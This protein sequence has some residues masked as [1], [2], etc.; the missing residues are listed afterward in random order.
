MD[1]KTVQEIERALGAPQG[2]EELY[3]WLDQ[4]LRATH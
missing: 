2:L 3:S 1:L 4:K